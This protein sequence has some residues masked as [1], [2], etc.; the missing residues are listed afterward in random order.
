MP[1]AAKGTVAEPRELLG[2]WLP[3]MFSVLVPK[4]IGSGFLRVPLGHHQS[5]RLEPVEVAAGCDIYGLDG[6][7]DFQC[8]TVVAV[9]EAERVK[10]E[11]KIRSALES[12]YGLPLRIV[13]PR[14]YWQLH[15]YTH[16]KSEPPG[17][18]MPESGGKVEGKR[19]K[20]P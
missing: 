20:K 17:S 14:I 15:P 4:R 7:L 10:F 6:A 1:G 13:E 5:A 9:Y 2:C 8:G 19:T 12:A 3:T 18:A 11:G 16:S